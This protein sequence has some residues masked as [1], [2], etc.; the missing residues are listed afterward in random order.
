MFCSV[1]GAGFDK[2]E[3][4]Y[5]LEAGLVNKFRQNRIGQLGLGFRV[6]QFET[7]RNFETFRVPIRSR[8][9]ILSFCT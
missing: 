3:A 4:L 8:F 5:M 2:I 1:L 6:N 9:R 7:V